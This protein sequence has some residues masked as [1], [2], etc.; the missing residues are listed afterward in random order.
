ME[1]FKIADMKGGWFMGNFSPTSHKTPTCEAC[2]K[3]HKK[4]EVWECHY[5][6]LGTEINF[7]IRG[8]MILQGVTLNAGDIFV[9]KPYEIADPEF[10]EDCEIVI[11]KTPS[12]P[13][14]KFN[15][16]K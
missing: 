15:C 1:V 4:W 6:K 8:K 2:Y 11:V 10:L 12:V 9:I 7:L 16:S 3:I 13:G 14:D 5:H